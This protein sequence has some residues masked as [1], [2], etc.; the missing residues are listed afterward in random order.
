MINL[1]C[2][3]TILCFIRTALCTSYDAFCTADH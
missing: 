2:H 1:K 3:K